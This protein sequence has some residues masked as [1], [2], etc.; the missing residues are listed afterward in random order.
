MS[1]KK[2]RAEEALD[3]IDNFAPESLCTTDPVRDYITELVSERDEA[4]QWVNDLHCGMY[5]NCVYCGHRYGPNSEIPET[6]ADVLTAHIAT[7]PKHPLAAA[8]ARITD[9]ERER[10]EARTLR[11]WIP[12]TE[13]LPEYEQEVLIYLKETDDFSAAIY[14]EILLSENFC[15]FTKN[16]RDRMTHW[17][18]LPEPP[19]AK[20]T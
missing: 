19:N 16:Q 15:P 11:E 3:K 20:K 4:H 1:E 12:V 7:C 10:D 2:D 8:N 6:M 5:V 18:A 9:L 14:S 13:R 17:M